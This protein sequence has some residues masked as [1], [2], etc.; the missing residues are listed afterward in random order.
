MPQLDSEAF[1]ADFFLILILFFLLHSES[2][3]FEN[4]LRIRA[5]QI[6][7]LHLIFFVNYFKLEVACLDLYIQNYI[8]SIFKKIDQNYKFKF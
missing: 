7:Y 5:R 8:K 6:L 3:I 2:T 4:F 1:F